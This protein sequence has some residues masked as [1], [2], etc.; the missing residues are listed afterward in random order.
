M[1]RRCRGRKEVRGIEVREEEFS[2]CLISSISAP[3]WNQSRRDGDFDGSAY[4]DSTDPPVTPDP[5]MF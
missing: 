4:K 5:L 3:V 1:D 2:D